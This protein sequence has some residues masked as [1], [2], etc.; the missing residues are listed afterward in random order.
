MRK[1]HGGLKLNCTICN[2]T[3]RHLIPGKRMR[4]WE[5]FLYQA[6]IKYLDVTYSFTDIMMDLRLS[7]VGTWK[8]QRRWE[9]KEK[10]QRSK[11]NWFLCCRQGCVTGLCTI[12]FSAHTHTHRGQLVD[13]EEIF[14]EFNK[15]LIRIGDCTFEFNVNIWHLSCKLRHKIKI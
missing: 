4:C 9:E 7:W 8:S 1:K 5:T 13:C 14:T 2:T 15:S 6:D 11:C 3:Q 12:C 10:R